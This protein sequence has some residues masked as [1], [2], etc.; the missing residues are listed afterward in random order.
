MFCSS[1]A[2]K[3]IVSV[4]LSRGRE[5]L[6]AG[7]APAAGWVFTFLYGSGAEQPAGLAL[8]WVLSVSVTDQTQVTCDDS[9]Q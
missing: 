7:A 5:L 9:A 4:A 3:R 1:A 8:D 6:A 2:G